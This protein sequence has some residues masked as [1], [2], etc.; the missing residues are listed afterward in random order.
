MRRKM[1]RLFLGS[2]RRPEPPRARRPGAKVEREE[3]GC[4][5]VVVKGGGAAAL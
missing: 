2:G 4:E 3:R 1:G 5:G